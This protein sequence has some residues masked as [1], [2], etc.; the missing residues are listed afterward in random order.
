M[1]DLSMDLTHVSAAQSSGKGKSAASRLALGLS[2]SVLSLAVLGFSA[3]LAPAA[4]VSHTFSKDIHGSGLT[5][6]SGPNEVA[7]DNNT[8]DIYVIDPGNYRIEEFDAAGNFVLMFGKDV[9]ETT[10]G[11]VCPEG[12]TDICKPGTAGSEPGQFQS[13][14]FIAVDN[15]DG[16]SHGDVYVSDSA[17][18]RVQKFTEAGKPVSSWGT[19]GYEYLVTGTFGM[20]V[21]PEGDL[22]TY[23][24]GEVAKFSQNGTYLEGTYVG[25]GGFFPQPGLRLDAFGNFYTLSTLSFTDVRPFETGTVG[26]GVP[27]TTEYPTT[28]YRFDFST[29]ELYQDTGLL[30]DHYSSACDAAEGLCSPIDSFGSSD[31][32]GSPEGV[33]IDESSGTVYVADSSENDVVAFADVRPKVVTGPPT[34]LKTT[35]V[36]LTGQVD[37][38][39]RGEISECKFEYGFNTNYGRTVPCSPSIPPDYSAPTEVT[40]TI[41]N[42]SPGTHEH[43]RLVASNTAG[44]SAVGHDETFVTPAPPAVDGLIAEK[45]TATSAELI[46]KI[47]PNGLATT[48]RFQ[49]GPGSS[50]GQE[51]TGNLSA[52]NSD[53]RVEAQLSN[54][55][56]HDVYHYRLVAEN[57]D[58]TTETEDHTFNFYPP[59]CP[60]E[61]VRQQTEANFLPDCRA[62]ELVSP[63]N[64]GGTQLFPDGP[65][66]GY[67]TSP[68]RFAY[69][70]LFSTIP[71][72]G[73][74]PIDGSGDLY[75]A[76]RT[77]TGWVS[78][79]VGIPSDEAAVDGGPPM[80]PPGSTP[81]A[82]RNASQV[83]ANGGSFTG[84]Q[85]GVIT[86]SAMDT[87]LD[88]NDGNQSVE[89]IFGADFQNHTVIASNAPYV[90]S[91]DGSRLGRWPTNLG[92]VP[93]GGY[94]TPYYYGH[95]GYVEAGEEPLSVAPGG[96]KSLNC[97]YVDQRG[98]G[99][100]AAND[101]PGD[102]TASSANLSHF[103]FATEWN[104]FAPG[105]NLTAPGS[106]YDN[107]TTTGNV[108][109]VSKTAAGGPIPSEPA[110]HAGDP[111]QIPAVSSDGSHILMAAGGTGPCGFTTCPTPPCGDDYNATKRCPMQSSHLYMRVDDTITYD[112]SAGHEVTY[113]GM[114]EDGSK[115]YFT[116]GE[117]LT[118]EDHDTSSDLYMWSEEGEKE[119]HPL[120]LISKGNNSAKAGEPGNSDACDVGFTTKCGVLPYNQANPYFCEQY[121]SGT[122]GNCLS[123]NFIAA[124]NGDIYFISP[125]QLDGT[126]GIPNQENLY[127]YREGKVQY[128]TSLTGPS[129][130]WETYTA[131][132]CAH[133]VRMQVSPDDSHMAFMTNSPVTQ[134]NNAGHLEMYLYNPST[135]R[136]V[137]ASC[138]PDGE[139]PL[140]NVEAS[141]DGLFM[142]NDGR[143]FFT[144]DDALVHNDTNQAQ[145]VYEYVDGRPQLITTGTGQTQPPKSGAAFGVSPGLIGVSSDGRDVYFS[146]FDTLVPED[147][148]GVFLKFYDARSGGGFPS[149]P[150]ATPCEAADE[151]H[152]AGSSAPAPIRDE[153]GASLSGG[154]SSDPHAVHRRNS[155]RR[156]RE[157]S[158]HHR[159][160]HSGTTHRGRR[161]RRRDRWRA[162]R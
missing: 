30:I 138:I 72:S 20:D 66:S 31:L 128:V 153:T 67:A 100:P 137:C 93:N 59:S 122:G 139:A 127:V 90:W 143:V 14:N 144:T 21:G 26:Q 42:L 38:E 124:Q 48:Y 44:G 60:N 84:S 106:V 23:N 25:N 118:S 78:R 61:N 146:T 135:Q 32:P 113:V 145:D 121:P 162:A 147:H 9:N 95:G 54:L 15:S 91:A 110:D 77:D 29:N 4:P 102:V 132:R 99:E 92:S 2:V 89:S 161:A 53:Q 3:D 73:G 101:C 125:E 17:N 24:G 140:S 108:E 5:A 18:G 64:A 11:N 159:V 112:V 119:G 7:V 16:P 155:R 76:T 83:A 36:T 69:T 141:Q 157:V 154:N 46:G 79:Y 136:L 33:A 80:G 117:Q 120:T 94:I 27:V 149:P 63:G 130:C 55:I 85:N 156:H 88:F 142:S 103:V 28:G 126:R 35:S 111:L 6:L 56:P 96:V 58:G 19:P 104:A 86:D 148:N 70:G 1:A 57:E 52:G 22:Y 75:V 81:G 82:I 49:Y 97:P 105:G 109:I 10:G 114:T 151:C 45:L 152:G 129:Y 62:Y 133:V 41:G 68:S 107:D 160:R 12:P 39:G 37:P 65:N 34:D 131:E 8:H 13:P 43:Y 150:P 74:S 51:V 87:F 98:E 47:N 40:A 71:K 123:D 158:R 115:V 50:Y 134:Y 116:S